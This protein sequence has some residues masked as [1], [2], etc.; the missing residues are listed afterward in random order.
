M[1]KATVMLLVLLGGLGALL[2]SQKPEIQ[3]YMKMEKM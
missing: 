2:Y 1:S 3:R